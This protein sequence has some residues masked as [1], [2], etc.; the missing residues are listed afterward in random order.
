MCAHAHEWVYSYKSVHV[1]MCPCLHVLSAHEPRVC[2]CVAMMKLHI[3]SL[4]SCI[5]HLAWKQ[6]NYPPSTPC[7]VSMKV[8]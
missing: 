6:L 4:G 5:P 3:Y 7:G 2:I 8:Q 1:H